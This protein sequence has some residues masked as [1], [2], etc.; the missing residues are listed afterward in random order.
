MQQAGNLDENGQFTSCERFG[1]R[2]V[3]AAQ[4][5]NPPVI[6]LAAGY[7]KVQQVVY[8]VR[9]MLLPRDRGDCRAFDLVG[10]RTL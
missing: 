1:R 7:R 4:Y 9:A 5:T 2:D 3:N 6:R 10:L 8:G